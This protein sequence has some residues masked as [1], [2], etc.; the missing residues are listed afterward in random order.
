M[1]K[2]TLNYEKWSN[3]KWK[4]DNIVRWCEK[5]TLFEFPERGR[6]IKGKLENKLLSAFTIFE[7]DDM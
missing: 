2:K 5:I 7:P 3:I 4:K 6:L 1:E